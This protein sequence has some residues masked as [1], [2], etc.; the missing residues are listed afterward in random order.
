MTVPDRGLE[1]NYHTATAASPSHEQVDNV[2][3]LFHRYQSGEAAAG[4]S[5]W[6]AE[7][8]DAT[9]PK[10]VPDKQD[11]SM[12]DPTREEIQA[13][14][15]ASEARGDTRIVRLEG[16]LETM[17]AALSGKLTPSAKRFPLTMST[18]GPRAGLWLD[19]LSRWR[20]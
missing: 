2:F 1:H 19:W 16:K 11:L 8:S 10:N 17:Q 12:S 18:T 9:Q 3:P 6:N 13:Q 14:I 20:G 15:A 4:R 5:A 7:L